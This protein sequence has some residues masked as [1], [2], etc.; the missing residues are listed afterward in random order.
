MFVVLRRALVL[1]ASALMLS[2]TLATTAH[3]ATSPS[4]ATGLAA[5]ATTTTA[6]L[7]WTKSSHTAHYRPCVVGSS[8]AA[9]KSST[10]Q[11]TWTFE[12]LSPR[13]SYR[14]IVYSFTAHAPAQSKRLKVPPPPTPAPTAPADNPP[15]L[16]TTDLTDCRH[17]PVPAAHA[18]RGAPG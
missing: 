18:G 4:P 11:S 7:T 15:R 6:T 9:Q 12:A 5:T 14:F 16:H 8:C 17:A 2:A 3:A 13:H 1:S 10:K